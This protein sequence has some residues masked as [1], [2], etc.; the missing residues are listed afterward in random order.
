[1]QFN[2]QKYFY[3]IDMR[4]SEMFN[5]PE[6]SNN[7]TLDKALQNYKICQET[8]KG[9]HDIVNISLSKD[10]IYAKMAMDNLIILHNNILD[11]IENDDGIK[12]LKKKIQDR[13]LKVDR[14]INF[15]Y[16]D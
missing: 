2:T 3:S 16:D 6:K 13:E 12:Q 15:F 4:F 5:S 11:L 10:D 8:M 7:D 14:T 9:I 1:M